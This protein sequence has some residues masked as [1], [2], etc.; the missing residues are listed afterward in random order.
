M[1]YVGRRNPSVILMALFTGWVLAPFVAFLWAWVAA[2]RWTVPAR[3]RLYLAMLVLTL[4][5]LAIYG[6]VAL[7]PPRAKPA[8]VF[9]M[10]P[11]V[12]WLLIAIV[13]GI[14]VMSGRRARQEPGG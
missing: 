14:P 3:I 6:G 10:V 11:L 13:V 2:R 7:G 1:L 8:S 9:L 4:A 12:S 5:S